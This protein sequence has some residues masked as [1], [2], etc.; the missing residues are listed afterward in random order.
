MS[1]KMFKI[2]ELAELFGVST[3]I[4]R[5]YDKIGL[6]KPNRTLDNGY[7]YYTIDQIIEL[8]M[9]L[10]WRSLDMPLDQ[11]KA[12]MHGKLNNSNDIHS[13]LD[14]QAHDLQ[15]RI[16]TLQNMLDKTNT[17][18]DYLNPDLSN[19]NVWK[20]GRRPDF[21]RL[22]RTFS[23]C[24]DP[25]VK[26]LKKALPSYKKRWYHDLHFITIAP[27]SMLD[28]PDLF[29]SVG[30]FTYGALAP[31]ASLTPVKLVNSPALC[32][33]YH[34]PESEIP[35]IL[36][37]AQKMIKKNHL[38]IT[39]KIYS[40]DLFSWKESGKIYIHSEFYIDLIE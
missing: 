28:T 3:D 1:K 39:D 23:L 29:E 18:M 15:R 2:G 22:Q 14:I 6:L 38:K 24:T 35:D 17:Y 11:I 7:R 33:T 8:E 9:I 30:E 20:N 13:I 31:L 16:E 34:G 27:T 12:L 21:Y 10:N 4:L 26:D 32:C 5:H 25:S 37:S 19:I 36:P 40:F